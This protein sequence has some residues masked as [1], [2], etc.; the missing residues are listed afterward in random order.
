MTDFLFATIAAGGG[1]VATANAMAEELKRRYAG[2]VSTH[3]S[4]IMAEFGFEALDRH[5][6]QSWKRMLKRP[7]LVRT[8]QRLTDATPGLTRALQNLLLDRFA[9][10][11]ADR[12]NERTPD[13]VVA[14]HGWL[15]T[16]LTRSRRKY[17]LKV[18]VVVYATEP[19]DAS[20]LWAE[21][22]VDEMIAPS[23][24]AREDLVRLGVPAT[25]I[26]VLGYP[27]RQAFLKPPDKA[28]ARA[29]LDLDANF[30]CLLSLGA[31][32][33]AGEA[34]SIARLLVERGHQVLAVAG[35][36]VTL[37]RALIELAA[38][39]PR[40]AP[41]GFTDRMPE[42]LAAADVVIGKAGPASTMEAL[43][44]GRPV[45][46]TAFAGLNEE[47]VVRFLET[48]NLGAY[49]PDITTLDAELERW[50]A[51][52]AR[53]RAAAT[54]AALDFAGMTG[55]LAEHLMAH[56][57]RANQATGVT[58]TAHA[59]ET[60]IQELGPFEATTRTELAGRAG[61]PNQ[62]GLD[63]QRHVRG[64]GRRRG[65]KGTGEGT[66]RK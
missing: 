58:R 29:A 32:G 50:A 1:H 51:P 4:D 6:K 53:E 37:E 65:G 17:G 11:A 60:T 61:T 26:R 28:A 52:A 3:V 45:V 36:N 40:L 7:Q 10:E 21:P 18:P 13:L 2:A 8:G 47:R 35:R 39:N 38:D 42:L 63:P 24:S 44:V 49:A 15:A 12:L 54:A 34:L 48:R 66:G 19:F 16:A 31:E 43:A 33:V 5:H 27:V 57:T 64:A 46:V 56:A 23:L 22:Q 20:A 14:N 41:F 55:R 30:T 25:S 9:R 59:S 62:S